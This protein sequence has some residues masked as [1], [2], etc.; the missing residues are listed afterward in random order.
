ML[1]MLSSFLQLKRELLELPEKYIYK[2][3]MRLETQARRIVKTME[4]NNFLLF[5]AH[6]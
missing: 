6:Q 4:Q 2:K 3:A 5:C 1:T